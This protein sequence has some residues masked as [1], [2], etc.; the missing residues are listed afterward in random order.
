MPFLDILEFVSMMPDNCPNDQE[1]ND[2]V[3]D[4]NEKDW[5]QECKEKYP[6]VADIAAVRRVARK[7]MGGE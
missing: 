6:N 3:E 1:E 2:K 7:T 5:S 4:Q